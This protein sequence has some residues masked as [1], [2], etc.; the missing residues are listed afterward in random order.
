MTSPSTR[1]AGDFGRLAAMATPLRRHRAIT[2]LLI[3]VTA[4]A[5]AVL[6]ALPTAPIIQA[7]LLTVAR[8]GS[9]LPANLGVGVA[10]SDA[11]VLQFPGPMDQEA[12]R[13]RLGLAPA[14]DV[15]LVWN[16]DSS[17]VTLVP[18]A[19]WAT[20]QRY[21]IHVPAGTLMADG[22]ALTADWRASFTTQTAP[23][24]VSLGVSGVT[25]TPTADTPIVIQEVMASIG[26]P[27]SALSAATDD[28]AADASAASAIGL[29]FSVAMDRAYTEQAFLIVPA[30][31]GWFRWQGTTL[32]FTPD[33]R[34]VPGVRYAINVAGA[35]DA[36]GVRVGG[37]TSF[38]FTTRAGGQ[39]LTVSP[40]IGATGI[41]GQTVTIGFS[42]PMHRDATAAAFSLVDTVTGQSLAGPFAWSADG[43]TLTFTSE[44]ALAAGRTYTASLGAGARD[45]DGNPVAIAWQF[46]TAGPARVFTA[47][48]AVAA[49]GD[50]VQ[51]ALNQVNAGRAAYGLA[52]LSLD[53]AITAVAYAH[54]SDMLANGYFS[55]TSLDGTTYKQR[56]TNGGVSY[57]WSGENMCYLSGGSVQ[58]TLDWC[59]NGFW[60]EPYPGGGNHKDNI[61]NPNFRR[62]GIGI[63]V[64]ANKVIV[65]YDFTD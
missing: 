8:E 9:I 17:A 61:L 38:S 19:H 11:V 29:T 27:E 31:T 23:R 5:V 6:F 57:A 40:A 53:G 14:T 63:A 45:A 35:R 30:V 59:H 58:A 7:G 12:V 51:N 64:G 24:V 42:Q 1:V 10:S 39:A 50:M 55:H 26:Y 56:L 43:L 46:T 62:V 44:A 15:R 37:D 60:S 2:H 22:G 49:S 65:V 25:G 47:A 18:A 28:M 36:N 3:T 4:L 41:S 34:L 54:A 20:D 13:S 52:P 21:A 16:A 33:Q 48:P 32:W